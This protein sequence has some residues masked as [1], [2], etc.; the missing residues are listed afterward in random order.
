MSPD[1][2]EIVPTPGVEDGFALLRQAAAEE[3]AA[4]AA[5]KCARLGHA[6]IEVTPFAAFDLAY[7]CARCPHHWTEHR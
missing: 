4:A 2:L 3:R 6:P 7:V 5:E 1:L